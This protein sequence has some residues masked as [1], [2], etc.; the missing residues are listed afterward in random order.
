MSILKKILEKI[1]KTFIKKSEEKILLNQILKIVGKKHDS[2]FLLRAGLGEAYIFF[3]MIK[4]FIKKSNF[5]TPCIVS[6]RKYYKEFAKFFCPD[7]PFY[8]IDIPQEK[9]YQTLKTKNQKY[10]GTFFNINPSTLNEILEVWENY[11][12]GKE[13][14]HYID[15]LKELND[16]TELQYKEPIITEEI[17][18]SVEQ[19]TKK[20]N[21]DNFIILIPE[22]NFFH[23]ADELFWE[24]IEESLRQKGF[25]IFIN[26]VDLTIPEVYYL[27]KLSKGI[28][29][30][31]GGL[32]EVLSAIDVPKHI[33]YTR[34]RARVINSI[35]IFTLQKYPNVCKKTLYEYEYKNTNFRS[36]INQIFSKL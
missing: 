17:K 20:L 12:Q 25:D 19:K 31:R 16:I 32:S 6:H 22:A 30:L 29:A 8:L 11:R 35:D 14:R 5:R 36:I 13:K 33:I 27:A 26:S 7:I 1:N 34:N 10:K 28:I 23:K 9:L 18:I 21:K 24:T 2:I 3:Y 15:V 4:I